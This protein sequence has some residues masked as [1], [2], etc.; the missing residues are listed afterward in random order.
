[1]NEKIAKALQLL[2]RPGAELDEKKRA[3][4][5]LERERDPEAVVPL[6]SMLTEI[7]HALVLE[8]RRVALAVGATAVL[9]RELDG[10]APAQRV[11]TL[12]LLGFLAD[13]T[14]LPVLLRETH[15][16]AARVRELA[17]NALIPLRNAHARAT[18]ERHLGADADAGVRMAA[19][20]ALGE[21]ADDAAFATLEGA[22]RAERDGFVQ[23]AIELSI[24][25]GRRLRERRTPERRRP[26]LGIAV[27]GLARG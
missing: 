21:Y 12:R 10:A 23:V 15:H 4:A 2:A 17:V 19:A 24:A 7:E 13:P 16:E 11:E 18:L 5:T 3:L 26:G 8:L 25:R 27:G 20:Q 22:L 1:M 6:V 9:A 14:A